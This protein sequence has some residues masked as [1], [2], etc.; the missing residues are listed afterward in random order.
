M[1]EK[2]N[3]STQRVGLALL[4]ILAFFIIYWLATGETKPVEQPGSGGFSTEATT[5]MNAADSDIGN[6]EAKRDYETAKQHFSEGNE[7]EAER[8]LEQAVL[9]VTDPSLASDIYYWLGKAQ[10]ERRKYGPA[11]ISFT[12]SKHEDAKNMIEVIRQV[13]KNPDPNR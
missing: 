10:F 3:K 13:I 12:L 11:R 4:V 1:T 9:K 8:Y 2:R 7:E 5:T 6:E